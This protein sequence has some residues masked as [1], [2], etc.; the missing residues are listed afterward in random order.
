MQREHSSWMWD[1]SKVG[2]NTIFSSIGQLPFLVF[3]FC[4][5]DF[6]VILYLYLCMLDETCTLYHVLTLLVCITMP[7]VPF[8]CT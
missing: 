6:A 1:K 3:C 7:R 2:G 4:Y 5:L 8:G